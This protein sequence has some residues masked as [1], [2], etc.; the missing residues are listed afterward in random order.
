[1]RR[2]FSFSDL[3]ID[4][5]PQ[6]GQLVA[7]VMMLLIWIAIMWAYPDGIANSGFGVLNKP[8]VVQQEDGLKHNVT[9]QWATGEKL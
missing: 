5:G 1:M 9:I 3:T 4:A 7:L 6:L 8:D 2:G